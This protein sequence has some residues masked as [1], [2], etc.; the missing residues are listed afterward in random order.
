M[1]NLIKTILLAVVLIHC[2]ASCSQ[3]NVTPQQAVVTHSIATTD[4]LLIVCL[5]FQRPD[6]L[7][8]VQQQVARIYN[9]PCRIIMKPLPVA[10]YYK[11]RHRYRAEKLIAYLGQFKQHYKFVAGITSVDISTTTNDAYDYGI[12]GLGSFNNT[13]CITSIKRMGLGWQKQV[14]ASRLAKV[15][16]HEVGHNNGLYHCT[17]GQPCFMDAGDGTIVSIDCDPMSLCARC[18]KKL[19]K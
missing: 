10:A 14:L 5:Q 13:A 15:V 16:L 4:T 6:L 9:I 11:P 18:Q 12:F 19:I 17:S 8:Y 3:R 7:P 1:Q 2:C